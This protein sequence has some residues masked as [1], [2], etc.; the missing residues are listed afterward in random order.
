MGS[1]GRHQLQRQQSTPHGI[2]ELVQTNSG[3]HGT[4]RNP[5]EG[6]TVCK[7]VPLR[8]VLAIKVRGAE[9]LWANSATDWSQ[10]L[11]MPIAIVFLTLLGVIHLQQKNAEDADQSIL[12]G[13][14]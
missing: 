7:L 3:R 13:R 12:F 2:E 8:L 6:V 14:V 1:I 10:A 11:Y 9:L 5:R 4:S